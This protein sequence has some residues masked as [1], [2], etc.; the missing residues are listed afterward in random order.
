M[1]RLRPRL[2]AAATTVIALAGLGAGFA[3]GAQASPSASAAA[4]S[5][6]YIAA[7]RQGSAVYINALVK[8]GSPSGIVPSPK[9]TAYLQ[10]NL[11]GSWQNMLSRVTNAQGRFTVGFIATPNYQ[12]RYV[13]LPTAN[14]L[15]TISGEA[16][17]T[18]PPVRYGNC[19]ALNAVYPHGVGRPGARD[20]TVSG[21]NPVLNFIVSAAVYT[22]N[23]RL[24]RD[25]DGIACERA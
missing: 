4:S 16:Q 10:R 20:H 8:Q 23:T 14:A 18:S 19:A 13:V 24:D 7:T 21:S 9:R 15:A 25:K 22:Q 17:T 2:L 5:Y 6:A 11:N 1:T 12:Y 3:A